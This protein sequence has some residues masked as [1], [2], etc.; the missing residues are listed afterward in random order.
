LRVISGT[1]KGQRLF[2]PKRSKGVNHIRPTSDKVRESIFNIINDRFDKAD[3][4]DLYAGTG[5]MGIEALS[6]GCLSAVF[7]DN[8]ADAVKLIKRNL[9]KCGFSSKSSVFK[10]D[11]LKSPFFLKVSRPENGFGLIIADPPY[12]KGYSTKSLEIID[13]F[14]LLGKNGLV[15]FEEAKEV[16][17]P[18]V[19]GTL[20]LTDRRRYGDTAVAIYS[21]ES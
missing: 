15:V 3:V 13:R 5:A 16:E 1:A 9:D 18:D 14:E 12:R 21:M 10:G 4:L 11:L 2:T 17:L 7:V 19:V 8:D 6:R 20:R